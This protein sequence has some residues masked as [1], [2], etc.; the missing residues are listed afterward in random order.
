MLK[1]IVMENENIGRYGFCV[2][3]YTEDA[4]GHVSLSFLG[5]QILTCSGIAATA[6]CFG[7]E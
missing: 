7:Y 5:N 6:L 4:K 1:Y 2:E 3:P